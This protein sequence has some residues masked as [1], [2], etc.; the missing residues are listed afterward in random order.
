LRKAEVMAYGY[1][2][3]NSSGSAFFPNGSYYTTF[4]YLNLCDLAALRETKST[5]SPTKEKT[6]P[7]NGTGF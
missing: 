6:G 2:I 7:E 1:G 4:H 3:P 5:F